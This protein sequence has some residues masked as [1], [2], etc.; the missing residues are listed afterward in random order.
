[1]E[2]EKNI[3][4]R[5]KSTENTGNI[6]PQPAN[7]SVSY[8]DAE[9]VPEKQIIINP[10]V[11]V[12]AELNRSSLRGTIVQ[13]KGIT[14]HSIL[15]AFCVVDYEHK[16]IQISGNLGGGTFDI[17]G[18][19]CPE[20]SSFSVL[21]DNKGDNL[22]ALGNKIKEISPHTYWVKPVRNGG[23]GMSVNITMILFNGAR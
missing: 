20:Y 1:M 13:W 17:H 8:L 22:A 12:G 7:T 18:S 10:A 11:I 5:V 4:T 21:S 3:K 16:S 6:N 15:G 9:N 23:S 19:N 2:T 14:E